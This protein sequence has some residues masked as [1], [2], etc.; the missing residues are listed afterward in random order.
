MPNI[1]RNIVAAGLLAAALGL[2][3]A[4]GGE[5]LSTRFDVTQF[6]AKGDGVADDTDA[7]QAALSAAA[8]VETFVGAGRRHGYGWGG[9]GP[10][11]EVYFPAG[12]YRLTRMLVFPGDK[13]SGYNNAPRK[14]ALRGEGAELVQEGDCDLLFLN[15]VIR[16][17]MTGFTLRGGRVQLR[18]WTDNGDMATLFVRDCAFIGAKDTAIWSR[19]PAD[20]VSTDDETIKRSRKIPPYEVAWADG[21][22]VFTPAATPATREHY[23]S[24]LLKI[25][26][27]RF[28][29]CARVLDIAPDHAVF[30]D[31]EV[32]TPAD[33]DG[34]MFTLMNHVYFTRVKARATVNPKKE[35]RWI[36]FA[37][38]NQN[39]VF[40]Y[41]RELDFAAEGDGPG[42]CFMR[43]TAVPGYVPGI[44]KLV[45]SVIQ[46]AGSR[47]KAMVWL[48]E[49][50]MPNML[51]FENISDPSN[52]PVDAV[53]WQRAPDKEELETKIRYYKHLPMAA[54]FAFKAD[55]L[56]KNVTAAW[57]AALRPYV[58]RPLDAKVD[59]KTKVE[60]TGLDPEAM[61]ATFKAVV[62]AAE[63]GVDRD[64]KTDDTEAVE[65][66]LA[67]A[68]ALGE[69]ARVVFPAAQIRLSR[70]ITVPDG[71]CL[72]AEGVTFFVLPADADFDAFAFPEAAR[73]LVRN[74]GVHNGRDAFSVNARAGAEILFDHC[75]LYDQTGAGV[76]LRG[77]EGM[78]AMDN[79]ARLRVTRSR[80]ITWRAVVSA[81]AQTEFDSSW[82]VNDTRLTDDAMTHNLG[83]AFL[84]RNLVGVPILARTLI[85]H[86]ITANPEYAG[87]DW[88]VDSHWLLNRGGRL[89][90]IGNRFG[91]EFCGMSPVR[92]EGK[93]TVRVEEGSSYHGNLYTK[94]CLVYCLDMPEAV[95]LQDLPC[96]AEALGMA[97][98]RKT[99]YR[100]VWRRLPGGGD[101]ALGAGL[102]VHMSAVLMDGPKAQA[103]R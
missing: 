40:F 48:A 36:D 9:D 34:P 11:G 20:T 10:Y 87:A 51:V 55:K 23:H 15:A 16:L 93:G 25:E 90:A 31:C 41:G 4:R 86:G 33:W 71:L 22:P 89:H 18:A 72:D 29:D 74:I 75:T 85:T 95:V 50:T 66:A 17:T 83:G 5:T 21:R 91:G 64:T 2:G 82:L 32:R 28:E 6:G 39:M 63:Y 78:A 30:S 100:A 62:R 43:S 3:A 53:R 58:V 60:P 47:E 81:A 88:G 46:S 57:P 76:R 70:T 1:A 37:H 97:M 103:A 7:I 99:P 101:D 8:R 27:S 61:A 54:Q 26:F 84:A 80:F 68:A 52:K 42:L 13:L 19:V 44:V 24:T 67:A 69:P 102:P 92:S 79:G 94:N 65:R 56:A 38:A 77:P 14:I 45:D 96:G 49:G 59:A 98:E 35:Q 12:A 73:A